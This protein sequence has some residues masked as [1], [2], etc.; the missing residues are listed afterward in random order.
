M[1]NPRQVVHLFT[2]YLSILKRPTIMSLLNVE[3]E[4]FLQSILQLIADLKNCLN[5]PSSNQ[6]AGNMSQIVWECRWLR[7]VEHQVKQIFL[8]TKTGRSSFVFQINEI[9]K[10]KHLIEDK[11]GYKDVDKS[12]LAVKDETEK[13]LQSNFEMWR[14]DSSDAIKNGD[15]V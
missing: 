2:K 9:H 4:Q 8:S 10:V 15:L 5:Q 7:V 3:R 6:G 11:D 14:E 13:L 12:L 1:N